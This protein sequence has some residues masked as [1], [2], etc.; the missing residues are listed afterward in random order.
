MF[1]EEEDR[2][3]KILAFARA[4]KNVKVMDYD[5]LATVANL[6]KYLGYPLVGGSGGA[7]QPRKRFASEA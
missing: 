1:G 7:I 2:V 4:K 6:E 5:V 3:D